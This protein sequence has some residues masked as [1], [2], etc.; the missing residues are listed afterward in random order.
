MYT[1]KEVQEVADALEK[2]LHTPCSELEKRGSICTNL[3]S[4]NSEAF[5]TFQYYSIEAYQKW[6]HYSEDMHYPVPN[7]EDP[8]NLIN[9]SSAFNAFHKQ[10]CISMWSGEYGNLRISL[11]V[12]LCHFFQ[13]KA[14]RLRLHETTRQMQNPFP[15][16]RIP[17]RDESPLTRMYN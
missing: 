13:D 3:K 11:L 14:Y 9:K 17:V 2:M 7:P 8:K 15:N 5:S 1:S 4:I 16:G 12:H 10:K 6:P